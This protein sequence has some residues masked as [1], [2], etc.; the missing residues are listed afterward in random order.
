MRASGSGHNRAR[1]NPAFIISEPEPGTGES[2]IS[3]GRVNLMHSNYSPVIRTSS[4]EDLSKMIFRRLNCRILPTVLAVVMFLPVT[5]WT[6]SVTNLPPQRGYVNDF[7]AVLDEVSRGRLENI[8]E[9]LKQR[10]GIELV[11]ATVKSSGE[12]DLYEYSLNLSNEWSVGQEADGKKVLTLI[13]TDTGRF[14]TQSS[15]G[16]QKN[17]QPGLIGYM[18]RRMRPE[19]DARSYKQGLFAGVEAFANII[20]QDFNFT[21]AELDRPAIDRK[22]TVAALAVPADTRRPTGKEPKT[23]P[24]SVVVPRQLNPAL[25][26]TVTLSAGGSKPAVSSTAVEATKPTSAVVPEKAAIANG[27]PQLAAPV[28]MN[29][30]TR[31]APEKD[32]AKPKTET[33]KV[34]TIIEVGGQVRDVSGDHPAKFK[35]TRDVPQGFFIQKL[36]VNYNPVY[37]PYFLAAK[38]LEI[39][40]LDQRFTV[41]AGRFGK[42]RTQF[43]WDQIPHSFGTGKSFLVRT[44]PGLYQVSPTLRARLQTLSSPEARILPNSVLSNT[45]RQE[46]LTAPTTDVRLRRDQALFRQS[47]RPSDKVELYAQFSWLRN[48]GTRPMSAGTFVRRAVPAN[49]LADIGGAWEGVGQEF[50]EPIDHRTYGFK[51]GAQFRGDRWSAG[52]EYDLSLFRNRIGVVTFENPFRVTDEQG[53]LPNPANPLVPTCGASNRFRM[54]R[55]HTDLPPNNDSHTISFWAKVDLTRQTQVRGLFSLAYWTQNDDFVPWTLNTAIVPRIWDPGPPPSP[56]I[57]PTDVNELPA[58]SLNGKM[59]NINQEYALVNRKNNF[60]FQAQ[61]RSQSLDTQ[62]APIFF[63][64]YAAFGDS[65]WRAPGTDFYNLPIENLDWDFRHQNVQSGFQWD[66]LP[67]LTWKMDYEWDIW[68]RKFRDVNRNNEHSIRGRLDFETNLSGGGKP[69]G[70]KNSGATQ[71]TMPGG[72]MPGS[73]TTLRLKADYRYSNRRALVYNTQPLTLCMTG[74]PDCPSAV[75][76]APAS[77]P[78]E[79]WVVT[80]FTVMNVGVPMEF[81]LL[82]RYDENDRTRNDASLTLELLKGPNTS[83]SASYRYLGDKH[84]KSFYGR[85]FNRFSFIDAEFSHAFENGVFLYA[86]YSR[87]TNSF[88]YRDLAHLLPNPAAPPGFIIQGTLA[89]YPIANT[90][91]RTSRSSLDSFQL[92]INAAPQEGKWQFDLSYAYSFARDRINTVNPFIPRADSILHAGVNP[93]PDT[94]VRRQ[95][96]NIV[97]TRRINESFEIGA[98]YWY[99]PYKQDDFSYNVLQPYAH[100]S[101]TSETP[102]YLFQDARYGSYRA[103][104]LSVFARYAFEWNK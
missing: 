85:L 1:G 56:V 101:L 94:V 99:E 54:V 51:L 60:R 16:A 100:G 24:A 57:N 61:Y 98:R 30:V 55:W 71:D 32:K 64:G 26:S 21:F 18:G 12:K 59:R 23:I 20:G 19:F 11:I 6:A 50:L 45:V 78:Q 17:L 34:D 52:V 96:L 41:D 84:D 86:N 95:D 89:Q 70:G 63:P 66:L 65:T 25:A 72:A 62:T 47:Y 103:N 22:A 2:M 93:Y 43:V 69:E 81:N 35:E 92:G 49:G 38:G 37:S 31:A 14:F 73:V 7:A 8:L 88:A 4:F 58:R 48:R 44:A 74:N 104:V 28:M 40:Q 76:G 91:E 87:E 42:Y 102:K 9:N 79:A 27:R 97:V 5:G 83:L 68:N 33:A 90:W 77:S 82:R 10:S 3:S 46:L 13:A 67:Q 29:A 15:R 53:C 80:R 75:G 36:K 39:L